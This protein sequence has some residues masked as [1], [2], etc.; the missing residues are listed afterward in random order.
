MVR[1]RDEARSYNMEFVD[2]R[3]YETFLVLTNFCCHRYYLGTLVGNY[4]NNTMLF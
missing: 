4:G 2:G 1:R 3:N